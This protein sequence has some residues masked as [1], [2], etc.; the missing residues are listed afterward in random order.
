MRHHWTKE[1]DIGL[2][3]AI[4]DCS[5]QLPRSAALWWSAVAGALASHRDIAV[6]GKAR[7]AR[8]ARLVERE[9]A[10]SQAFSATPA[11]GRPDDWA[12]ARLTVEAFVVASIAREGGLPD[13]VAILRSAH[14]ELKERER[15]DED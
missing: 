3:M 9:G 4:A 2:M 14:R 6:S 11:T 12:T 1:D 8:R 7:L 13:L 10:D 5:A 15:G